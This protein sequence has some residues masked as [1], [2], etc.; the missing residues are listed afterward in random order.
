MIVLFILLLAAMARDSVQLGACCTHSA[1]AGCVS[2]LSQNECLS[3][4]AGVFLGELSECTPNF[5]ILCNNLP[6]ACCVAATNDCNATKTRAECTSPAVFAGFGKKCDACGAPSA[7]QKASIESI[8]AVAGVSKSAAQLNINTDNAASALLTGSIGGVKMVHG[9]VLDA[10]LPSVAVVGAIVNL[11]GAKRIRLFSTKTDSNGNF[12]FAA[13]QEQYD[14]TMVAANSPFQIIVSNTADIRS[15]DGKY[16]CR[17]KQVS[18]RGL[19]LHDI[20]IHDEDGVERNAYVQCDKIETKKRAIEAFSSSSSSSSDSGS[21]S[22]SSYDDESSFDPDIAT[23]SGSED[24]DSSS[25]VFAETTTEFSD[26]SDVYSDSTDSSDSE[27]AT[28]DWSSSSSDSDDDEKKKKHH[29]SNNDSILGNTGRLILALVLLCCCFCG[30]LMC[31]GWQSSFFAESPVIY[32]SPTNADEKSV[33]LAPQPQAGGGAP[34]TVAGQAA[35]VQQGTLFDMIE[36][37]SKME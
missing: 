8:L 22:E 15:A 19:S 2:G 21:D 5:V 28:D 10:K 35:Y 37:E 27:D 30:A 3:A 11:V 16:K 36:S 1:S 31:L 34:P 29:H 20:V 6:G 23:S 17:A 18:G 24:S 33:P 32:A 12:V 14:D 26:S 7:R 9:R 13:P 4:K 25:T